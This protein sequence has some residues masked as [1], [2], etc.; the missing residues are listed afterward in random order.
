MK[1]TI[2]IVASLTIALIISIGFNAHQATQTNTQTTTK[3]E[4]AIKLTQA[5]VKINAQLKELSDNTASAAQQLSATGLSGTQTRQILSQL[6]E[7]SPY[8]IDATTL[9]LTCKFIAVEPS[10]YSSIEGTVSEFPYNIFTP[11]TDPIQTVL[12]GPFTLVEAGYGSCIM[13]PIFNTNNQMIGAL[14]LAFDQSALINATATQV[15]AGTPY[16]IW[17]SDTEGTM[18]YEVNPSEVGTNLFTDPTI[19]TWTQLQTFSLKM[20]TETAGYGTYEYFNYEGTD[21]TVT[22]QAYWA[23]V[24]AYNTEW[25]LIIT[26][27]M[28]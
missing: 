5:Q 4:M 14:S 12:E 20:A 25:R 11:S 3:L 8:I 15:C 23:T 9:D 10:T 17:A 28:A 22:K 2:L 26:N 27:V 7:S 24:G 6:A 16:V 21:K 19:S 13:A 1:K 18:V